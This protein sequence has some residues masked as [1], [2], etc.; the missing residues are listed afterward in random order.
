MRNAVGALVQVAASTRDR[1]SD[2]SAAGEPVDRVHPLGPDHAEGGRLRAGGVQ[3]VLAGPESPERLLADLGPVIAPGDGS[4][5][6]RVERLRGHGLPSGWPLPFQRHVCSRLRRRH[7]DLDRGA[8]ASVH[9][10]RRQGEP[11]T[12][13]DG[14]AHGGRRDGGAG[15][16]ARDVCRQPDPIGARV[17]GLAVEA[18]GPVGGCGV[19]REDG[20]RGIARLAALEIHLSPSLARG[21]ARDRTGQ[22]DVAAVGHLGLRHG[23]ESRARDRVRGDR[24]NA[25]QQGD[26]G[27]QRPGQGQ[28]AESA[29]PGGHT[30]G[31]LLRAGP[32]YKTPISRRSNGVPGLHFGRGGGAV[33]RSEP[34]RGGPAVLARRPGEVPR[35]A[36]RTGE[37]VRQGTAS[38]PARRRR[39]LRRRRP[40]GKRAGR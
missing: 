21:V 31:I 36:G 17:L 39:R 27:E 38:P 16:L 29:D 1:H 12:S 24:R 4:A 22:A 10:V 20:P 30:A 11:H 32:G 26:Q 9:R 33:E 3:E 19:H 6:G 13:S 23:Q 40:A 15:R 8:S 18:E 14:A 25:R 35:E 28:Q 2:V 5:R 34:A 7:L 37:A